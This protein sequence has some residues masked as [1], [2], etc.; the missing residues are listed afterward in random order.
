MR[1]AGE[2]QP[3]MQPSRKYLR[4]ALV[5]RSERGAASGPST[6]NI[7][8]VRRSIARRERSVVMGRSAGCV[9]RAQQTVLREDARSSSKGLCCAPRAAGSRRA[10]GGCNYRFDRGWA[11]VCSLRQTAPAHAIPS[12]RRARTCCRSKWVTRASSP[13]PTATAFTTSSTGSRTIL[14]CRSA[15]Q[16]MPRAPG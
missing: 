4:R 7:L 11:A 15:H 3:V 9:L 14:I 10:F 16:F 13:S 5:D 12:P 6:R 2:Q 8:P 1:P